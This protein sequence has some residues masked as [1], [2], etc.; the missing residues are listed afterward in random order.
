MTRTRGQR[1]AVLAAAA[2]A[3]SEAKTKAAER[4]IRTLVKRDV[5]VTFQAVQR[6]AGVSH[7][8]LYNQRD[9][10]SR[11]EHLRSRSTPKSPSAITPDA[12][13]T[14]VHALTTERARLR[15]EHRA[16][17]KALKEALEQ[18]HGQIIALRRELEQRP[19]KRLED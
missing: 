10:R 1:T 15:K 7:S 14:L 12:E 5:P 11:I 13:S 9:L 3:R 6:E 4:A 18:A 2:K 16:E 19:R 17:I 8:F